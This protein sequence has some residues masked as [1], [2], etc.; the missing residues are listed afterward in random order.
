[1][2]TERPAVNHYKVWWPDR[3]QE[4]ADA[5]T[6]IAYDP[7]QAAEQ[8]ANWYDAYNNDYSIVGGEIA[9]VQVL[10]D[11]E[12]TAVTVAVRGFPSREYSATAQSR[13]RI[14]SASPESQENPDAVDAA[15]GR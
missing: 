3:D 9:E 15:P 10:H 4:E 6:V 2:S 14:G 7:E 5:K 8:W 13:T 12:T 11:G 1:M